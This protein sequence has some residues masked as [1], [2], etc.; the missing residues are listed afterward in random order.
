[1]L[2]GLIN[3]TSAGTIH[4]LYRIAGV[5]KTG[6]VH[7]LFV[8]VPM[9]AP[10]PQLFVENDRRLDFLIAVFIVNTAPE[11]HYGVPDNHSLGVNECKAGAGLVETK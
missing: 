9:A 5:V 10:V 8:I 3:Q 1:M 4:R 7:I 11:V 6:K 2:S